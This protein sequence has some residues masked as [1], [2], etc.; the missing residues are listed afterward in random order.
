MIGRKMTIK[1]SKDFKYAGFHE[2]RN[3]RLNAMKLENHLSL[4]TSK[5]FPEIQKFPYFNK[6]IKL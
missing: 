1:T 5:N 2:K 6:I 3:F 4:R